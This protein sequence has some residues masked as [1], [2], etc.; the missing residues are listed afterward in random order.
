[1]QA[2][3]CILQTL[4]Q[5]ENSIVKITPDESEG[6]IIT[7]D[8]DRINTDGVKAIGEL[9]CHLN[10]N[11]AMANATRGTAYYE[12]MTSVH[13][14]ELQYREIVLAKRKP[15]KEY[16]QP[17]TTLNADGSDVQLHEFDGSVEGMLTSFIARHKDIPL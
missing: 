14:Q 16:V 9:L 8:A 17:H 4:L 2:R 1:M 10:I 3:Y 11:K 5:C 12:K 15:R 13:E 6:L 7:I